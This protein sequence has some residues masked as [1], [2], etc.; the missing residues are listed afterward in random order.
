MNEGALFVAN[1]VELFVVNEVEIG[2]VFFRTL[3]L[4]TVST[5]PPMLYTP[6]HLYAAS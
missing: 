5:V 6:L 1:E 2:Q 4:A 3:R